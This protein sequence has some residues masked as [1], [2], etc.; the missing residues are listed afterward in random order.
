MCAIFVLSNWK[1][2]ASR[3]EDNQIYDF[4]ALTSACKAWGV[5]LK[6]YSCAIST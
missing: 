1:C 2:I 6:F 5:R 3:A 4:A